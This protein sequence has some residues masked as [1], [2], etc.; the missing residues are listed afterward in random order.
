[1]EKN[2][3]IEFRSKSRFNIN[4]LDSK[5]ETKINLH[6]IPNAYASGPS[7]RGRCKRN[8]VLTYTYSPGRGPDPR[9]LEIPKIS[10]AHLV[11]SYAGGDPNS[12]PVQKL[13]PEGGKLT[14]QVNYYSDVRAKR[15]TSQYKNLQ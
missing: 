10:G 12:K 9:T 15:M 7:A 8:K 2:K 1:M 5:D 3:L 4:N 14:Q 6:K 13:V 11:E